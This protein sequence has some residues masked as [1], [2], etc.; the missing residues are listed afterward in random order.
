MSAS[1]K[2]DLSEVCVRTLTRRL[3]HL[4]GLWVLALER[5]RAGFFSAPLIG[6]SELPIGAPILQ[7]VVQRS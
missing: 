6:W 1:R 2:G 5:K 7:K 4:I 3:N